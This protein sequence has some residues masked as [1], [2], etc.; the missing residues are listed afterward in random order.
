MYAAEYFS[1]PLDF[2]LMD[3]IS[4]AAE[5]SAEKI[6]VQKGRHES[7][8]FWETLFKTIFLYACLGLLRTC[9]YVIGVFVLNP[10]I[11]LART[12]YTLCSPTIYTFTIAV[13]GWY[14]AVFEKRVCGDTRPPANKLPYKT[15][16]RKVLIFMKKT[17]PS[18]RHVKK[19]KRITSVC[20]RLFRP[21][22]IRGIA[23]SRFICKSC[24]I[25][26]HANVYYIQMTSSLPYH[27]PL[28]HVSRL[29]DPA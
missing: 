21:T 2:A 22:L 4:H 27:I 11:F 9:R 24:G 14:S 13:C 17:R 3:A 12:K 7:I 15:Q 20:I 26:F 23:Y 25:P 16:H 1:F 29:S 28:R 10:P 6:S 19:K 18:R 8:K 5:R